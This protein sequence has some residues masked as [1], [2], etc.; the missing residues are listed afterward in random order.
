MSGIG[1]EEREE[2]EEERAVVDEKNSQGQLHSKP[3][4]EIIELEGKQEEA[5]LAVP[6]ASKPPP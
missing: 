1:R 5:P 2:E 3:P 4:P 6:A